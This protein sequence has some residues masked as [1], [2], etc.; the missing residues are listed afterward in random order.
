[1]STTAGQPAETEVSQG[2]LFITGA[3]GFLG[4]VLVEQLL[5]AFPQR[6]LRLLFHKQTDELLELPPMVQI[7]IGDILNPDSFQ[8]ALHDVDS[9]IHLAALTGKTKPDEYSAVN[10][11]GTQ[12][13]LGAGQAAGVKSF[14]F[15]STIAA[16]YPNQNF[17]HYAKSKQ[18]AEV[19]VAESQLHY[20]ILRP[21]IVLGDGSPIG[22]TLA[23]VT[24][25]PVILLPQ[26]N[27][28]AMVQ[29][30]HV[31][32]VARG[33]VK[34]VHEN[35]Y[36]GETL[37]IGGPET[38][39]FRNFLSRMRQAKNSN[40]ARILSLPLYPLQWILSKAEPF[41]L[42]WMPA[43]AGQLAVFGNDSTA[44]ENWLQRELDTQ[45]VPLDMMLKPSQPISSQGEASLPPQD[46]N[47]KDYEQECL[48]FTRYL[49]GLEADRG[50]VRHYIKAN[51]KRQL[52][53]EQQLNTTDRATLCLARR[54][55]FFTR[56]ADAY[57]AL[58]HPG[59][60][61]RRKLVLLMAILEN[62]RTTYT[63]FDIV[64]SK[65]PLQTFL[66]LAF[67]GIS[68]ALALATGTALTLLLRSYF[69][70]KR[71]KG[72]AAT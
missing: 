53:D 41:F 47:V 10:T 32:D 72:A 48:K 43:T 34:V 36:T 20:T 28:P 63:Q 11:Q 54:G 3:G 70:C 64:P 29:P 44:K 38:L 68:F 13:L 4:K 22:E 2:A 58:F 55:S 71:K 6:R 62:S 67:Q 21:T 15:I 18:A 12:R 69:Y 60:A 59:G 49:T 5:A 27:K 8:D 14:L 40:T 7:I 16:G 50:I 56:S 24:S 23:K 19:A 39:L 66:N 46:I 65:H 31:T 25:L 37:E 26:S 35:R 1:M 45:L 61:L 57:C 33:I 52:T 51:Q 17:Y 9:I 42:S 30:I